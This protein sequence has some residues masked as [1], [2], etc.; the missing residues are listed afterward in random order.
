MAAGV[1]RLVQ[2]LVRPYRAEMN[3]EALRSWKVLAVGDSVTDQAERLPVRGGRVLGKQDCPRVE[4]K[5]E[6]SRARLT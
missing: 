6:H 2:G 4:S 3:G 5:P 1:L